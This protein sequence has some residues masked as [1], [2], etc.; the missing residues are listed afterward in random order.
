MT[1][2]PEDRLRFLARND[3]A[4]EDF[5]ERALVLLCGALRLREINA[6][7]RRMLALLDGKRTVQDIAGETGMAAA[8][9]RQALLEM[10]RQGMVRRVAELEQERSETMNE[11]TYLAD[12]DVSFRREGDEGGILYDVE[13][14]ALEV[15]NP[16][17]AEIWEFLAAPHTQAEIVAHLCEVCDGAARG[18]VEKDVAEFLGSLLKKGFVG[19]VKEPA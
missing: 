6:V 3:L 14:D 2:R 17:A 18:A 7:S 5:G 15:V 9:V 13:S 8:I 12:P 16:V 19:I 4:V 11:A 1:E 10:E